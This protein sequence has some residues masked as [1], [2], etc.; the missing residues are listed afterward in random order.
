MKINLKK[1]V[2]K[3]NQEDTDNCFKL[4][5]LAAKRSIDKTQNWVIVRFT[6]KNHWGDFWEGRVTLYE[7]LPINWPL[8]NMAK[9]LNCSVEELEIVQQY[10]SLT[11][12][13]KI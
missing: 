5:L 13:Q 6:N 1:F 4:S 12:W 9:R 10:N 2:K 8:E 7:A 3:L 11:G